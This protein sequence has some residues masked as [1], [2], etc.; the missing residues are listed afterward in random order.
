MNEPKGS[1]RGRRSVAELAQ[2]AARKARDD[3]RQAD[4]AEQLGLDLFNTINN[5]GL[6]P[7]IAAPAALAVLASY[8]HAV[9]PTK[10][11]AR[12]TIRMAI[13]LADP[14]P[15]TETGLVGSGPEAPAD[16]PP[17]TEGYRPDPDAD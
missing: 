1:K 6:D 8:I 10:T 7:M 12:Y 17:G 11:E 3:K 13:D 2:E 4:E 15:V 16:E 5:R 9:A 14:A